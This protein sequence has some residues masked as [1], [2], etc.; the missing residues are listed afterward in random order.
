MGEPIAIGRPVTIWPC[1]TPPPKRRFFR[2]FFVATNRAA[3]PSHSRF[4]PKRA[5]R[6]LIVVCL[7][8]STDNRSN[9]ARPSRFVQGLPT[10]PQAE[11]TQKMH[12]NTR[13]RRSIAWPNPTAP[14]HSDV[15]SDVAVERPR[16]FC[17]IKTRCYVRG[18]G[19][20]IMRCTGFILHNER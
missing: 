10:P 6:W 9:S 5:N 12:A 16:R 15:E 1:L 8:F 7:I 3:F 20:M 18:H 2:L 19:K 17:L 13:G 11:I 4:S 14:G